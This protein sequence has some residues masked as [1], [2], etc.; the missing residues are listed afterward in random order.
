MV[1]GLKSR[2]ATGEEE[3]PLESAKSLKGSV[4]K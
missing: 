2:K 3:S 4:R 1:S